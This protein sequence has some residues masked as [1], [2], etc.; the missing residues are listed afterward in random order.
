MGI[1]D[2]FLGGGSELGTFGGAFRPFWETRDVWRDSCARGVWRGHF[3]LLGKL[4]T[5]GG[6]VV[7]CFGSEL[8][9][10]GGAT[11]W[12]TDHR[13]VWRFFFVSRTLFCIPP[14]VGCL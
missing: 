4:G 3:A 1:C 13:D 2:V 8:G 5:F 14:I 10:L 9:T 6:A 11:I 7:T 12:E